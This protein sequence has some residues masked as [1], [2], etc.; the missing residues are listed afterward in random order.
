MCNLPTTPTQM[1]YGSHALDLLGKY[2]EGHVASLSEG[3]LH[4]DPIV[5][6]DPDQVGMV[7]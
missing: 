6:I 1:G 7:F 5:S 4:V 3:Q 2:Y